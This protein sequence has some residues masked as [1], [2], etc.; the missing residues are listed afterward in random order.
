MLPKAPRCPLWSTPCQKTPGQ[1]HTHDPPLF[2]YLPQRN[3]HLHT[4]PPSRHHA[5]TARPAS[6]AGSMGSP[7]SALPAAALLARVALARTAG[8][9]A[10]KCPCRLT[11]LC[12]ARMPALP[13]VDPISMARPVCLRPAVPVHMH[14][15]LCM[16][17]TPAW[18]TKQRFTGTRAATFAVPI[19]LHSTWSSYAVCCA[20]S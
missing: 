7:W 17:H 5:S 16:R 3:G 12:S 8:L 15:P 4:R 9:A 11:R 18:R 14:L 2:L 1:L 20:F 13:L 19:L 6:Y 10:L